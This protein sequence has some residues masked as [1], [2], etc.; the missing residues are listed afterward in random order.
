MKIGIMVE[1]SRELDKIAPV[2]FIAETLCDIDSF[3]DLRF[4]Q[5]RKLKE[6]GYTAEKFNSFMPLA[7]IAKRW[8]L[9][10]GVPYKYVFDAHEIAQWEELTN[11]C[12]I[13][14]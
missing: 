12:Q 3:D 8:S 9:I 11:I 6:Y 1:T 7:K 10:T 2:D 5:K 4:S 13:I 14:V